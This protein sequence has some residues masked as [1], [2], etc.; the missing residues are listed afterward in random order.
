M[1]LPDSCVLKEPNQQIQGMISLVFTRF[2]TGA[3]EGCWGDEMFLRRLWGLK[4]SS[5][6]MRLSSVDRRQSRAASA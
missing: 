6:A 5:L 4:P 3:F 1:R 2:H